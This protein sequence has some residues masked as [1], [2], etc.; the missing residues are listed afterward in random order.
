M[1]SS[2]LGGFS[3]WQACFFRPNNSGYFGKQKAQ[4]I[5]VNP[6]IV[7]CKF[8]S[9]SHYDF[10]QLNLFYLVAFVGIVGFWSIES[11]DWYRC[12]IHTE[13]TF[14]S[15]GEDSYRTYSILLSDDNLHFRRQ[16]FWICLL[17]FRHDE[18]RPDLGWFSVN[19]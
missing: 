14:F 16:M 8:F 2:S 17:S 3:P 11:E 13:Y 1:N 4:R 5:S 7:F 12:K 18:S 19:I 6:F 9:K 10:K 15:F